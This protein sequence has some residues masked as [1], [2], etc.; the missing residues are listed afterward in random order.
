MTFADG[1]DSVE[2][3]TPLGDDEHEKW[4]G[5]ISEVVAK[6]QEIDA[7]RAG[8]P[9][10]E[11]IEASSGRAAES[12]IVGV[13]RPSGEIYYPRPVA[14]TSDISMLASLRD[15]G[16]FLILDGPPGTGKTALV[17]AAFS[18]GSRGAVITVNCHG[19]IED[20]DLVGRY[21]VE[22][23]GYRWVDGP[24]PQAMRGGNVLFLDDVALAPPSVI[25][26]VYPVMDGRDRIV[27]TEHSNEEVVV[28]PGFYVVAAWNPGV[29]GSR[30]SEALSSRFGVH[31]HVGTDLAMLLKLGLDRDVARF[32]KRLAELRRKGALSWSPEARELFSY[33]RLTETIGRSAA[34]SNMLGLAPAEDRQLVAQEAT[35]FIAES[36]YSPIG[37]N[38]GDVS[39]RLVTP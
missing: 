12:P 36:L 8:A 24:L 32:A 22:P 13:A 31:M 5:E 26:R 3:S 27:L 38:L 35:S 1:S 34:I 6:A 37:L 19:D 21:V 9:T 16:E 15:K 39:G 17:E 7:A 29:V 2:G 23:Q 14:G 25:A 30:L 4:R 33:M 18:E 10:E 28:A 20:A 11:V